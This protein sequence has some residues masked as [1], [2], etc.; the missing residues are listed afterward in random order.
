MKTAVEAWYEA[1]LV[2]FVDEA[3]VRLALLLETSGRVMAQHGFTRS[4]DVMSACA[5]AAAICASAAELGRQLEGAPFASLHHPGAE[6]Q[7]FLARVSTP[8]G[9]HILLAVF[10]EASSLGLV[11]FYFG[12]FT[13]ALAA[14]TPPAAPLADVPAIGADFEADLDRNLS[15]LFGR[16]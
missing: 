10:D 4:V 3:R 14:A 8:R 9:P 7:L 12:A 11:K 16:A 13:T 15:T 2:R 5:L 6:R 1:P